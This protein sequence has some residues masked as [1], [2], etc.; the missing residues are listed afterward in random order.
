MNRTFFIILGLLCA[1]ITAAGCSSQPS[2]DPPQQPSSQDELAA[3]SELNKD[4]FIDERDSSASL[5]NA[6]KHIS[7]LYDR[8][9]T[10]QLRNLIKDINI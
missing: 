2:A 6:L 4:T 1:V 7:D 5:K 3:L 9:D 10:V 8:K